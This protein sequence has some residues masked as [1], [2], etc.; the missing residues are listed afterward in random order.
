ME[1]QVI[2]YAKCALEVLG[3]PQVLQHVPFAQVDILMLI[4]EV[5]ILLLAK[6]VVLVLTQ[7]Q[8]LLVATLIVLRVL[9][10]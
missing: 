8:A 9:M 7:F 5:Q 2:L 6:L 1:M 3:A 4:W 10:W